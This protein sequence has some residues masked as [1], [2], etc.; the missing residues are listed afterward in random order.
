MRDGRIRLWLRPCSV[1][2]FLR[3]TFKGRVSSKSSVFLDREGRG[4]SIIISAFYSLDEVAVPRKRSASQMHG[5]SRTSFILKEYLWD[6][7]F[8][9]ENLG[10]AVLTYESKKDKEDRS[11]RSQSD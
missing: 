2:H 4:K 5:I 6:R 9:N 1:A 3:R 7:K 8:H 11:H 10:M